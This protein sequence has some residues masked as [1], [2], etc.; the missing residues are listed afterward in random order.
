M[1]ADAGDIWL[2]VAHWI[3]LAAIAR[4]CAACSG[5]KKFWHRGQGLRVFTLKVPPSA[6]RALWGTLDVDE[7]QTAIFEA[8]S[9][10]T[11]QCMRAPNVRVVRIA[12]MPIPPLLP[13]LESFSKLIELSVS[14]FFPR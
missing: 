7:L 10:A 8:A 12:E 1:G 9:L 2:A 3:D 14:A 4:L 5:L 11:V 13:A 6:S